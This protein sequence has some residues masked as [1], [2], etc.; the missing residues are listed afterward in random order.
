MKSVFN[1]IGKTLGFE[2]IENFFI[3]KTLT[4]AVAF[5]AAQ[6]LL[7]LG[8]I[9]AAQFGVSV[10]PTK[11]QE[12]LLALATG[13]VVALINWLKHYGET[14]PTVPTTPSAPPAATAK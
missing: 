12:G 4:G 10:D 11:L 3:K 2:A 5:V 9:N 7:L 1:F 6:L 13:G 8:H 14:K